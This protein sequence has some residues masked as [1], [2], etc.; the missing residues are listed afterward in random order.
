MGRGAIFYYFHDL[1]LFIYLFWGRE[2]RFIIL[3]FVGWF[4]L[5]NLYLDSDYEADGILRFKQLRIRKNGEVK[6]NF[7][8][9]YMI[10]SRIKFKIRVFLLL[11]CGL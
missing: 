1:F 7:S 2:S 9:L 3:F 6:K 4:D 8:I 5:N 11:I 10:G